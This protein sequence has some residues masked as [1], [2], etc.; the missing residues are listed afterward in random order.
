MEE[1]ILACIKE[2]NIKFLESG[3]ISK[4]V[5]PIPRKEAHLKKIP[6][7]IVRV[8]IIAITPNGEIRYLV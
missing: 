5:F 7:L 8:F 6:H 1:E 4:Y 3:Q 2:E